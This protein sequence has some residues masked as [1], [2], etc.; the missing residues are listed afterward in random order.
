VDDSV[1]PE[2]VCFDDFRAVNSHSA[3]G[4]FN[5][6]FATLNGLHFSRLHIRCEDFASDDVIS[7]NCGEL[8]FVLRLQE[9]FDRAL[10][11]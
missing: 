6:E 9:V 5:V 7:E 1:G 8:C 4:D 2:D 10:R 11:R 3:I